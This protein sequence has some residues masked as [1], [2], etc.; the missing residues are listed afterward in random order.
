MASRAPAPVV[1]TNPAAVPVELEPKL[2]ISGPST[3]VSQ[4]NSVRNMPAAEDTRA[5]I[6]IKSAEKLAG[7]YQL[8][9]KIGEGGMGTVFI[10]HDS[11]LDR[12]VA[13]KML[14]GALVND[15]EVVER[16]EREAKLTAG[17]DHPNIVPIY[18]VGRHETRPFIVMKLL[19]GDTLA[20][21]LR[22][23][24][25]FTS[26]E[27][28]KLMKQLAAGL[29]YI[30]QRGFIHRDIKAGNI[31]LSAEGHATILDFGIL[32][33]RK[34]NASLTRTGMVMGT[35]H[36]MAPEQAMGLKDVDH[37]VDL[38]AL[39]VVLFEC[40]TGTLP[41]EAD[42][43]LRLIQMQA[44]SPPPEILD[45][46]P[47]IP[48]PVA[49]VVRKALSKRP[50]DRYYSGQDLVK[51]LESAYR[52]SGGHP[53]APR[54]PGTDVATPAAPSLKVLESLSPST[55]SPRLQPVGSS[56]SLPVVPPP[57][58][59]MTG[60]LAASSVRPSRMPM[61]VLSAV[62]LIAVG[63]SLWRPWE[64]NGTTKVDA[65]APFIAAVVVDA[66][67]EEDAGSTLVQADVDAGAEEEADA[68]ALVDASPA[69]GGRTVM[70]AKKKGKLNV[71][72][73]H[74]GEPYW[75]QVS[76]DGVPRG[77]TPLLLDLPAGKYQLRVE[78]PGFRIEERR[79]FVA[80]GKPVV[81]KI[82]L[83]P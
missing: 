63:I 9:Q 80:A 52:D 59:P 81:V 25:G 23:K 3:A 16:F 70:F 55:S 12:E 41:F 45:R 15:A 4:R 13:V 34:A 83:S 49:D 77:R 57:P 8:R 53:A 42:S 43:E 30:H 38:Y 21:V 73:M 35:P 26:D 64:T 46:A 24:G 2:H 28:L 44:H 10:A 32:R 72:T 65:G 29:D 1:E 66:G 20:G 69:D 67:A 14:A 39:A 19:Q 74:A 62:A 37:R 6:P 22:Q 17:L 18:D 7:R 47:W 82:T 71:I 79:V 61:V 68:G 54:L 48:R 50:D 51:A 31:F 75:A 40:L 76:V 27:T 33:S 36:Y 60:A 11:E 5:L 56:P 78:R 58:G